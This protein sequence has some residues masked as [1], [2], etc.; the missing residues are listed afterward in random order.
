MKTNILTARGSFLKS[1]SNSSWMW[2]Y[3]S[4]IGWNGVRVT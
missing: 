1:W 3:A 2:I 4:Q